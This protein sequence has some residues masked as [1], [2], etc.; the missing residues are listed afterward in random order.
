MWS[1]AR[2]SVRPENRATA[3]TPRRTRT[4]APVRGSVPGDPADFRVAGAAAWVP[5]DL[6]GA[7]L[8]GFGAV[9]VDVERTGGGEA[10]TLG[11]FSHG[12]HG[13]R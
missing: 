4:P 5:D 13:A 3:A 8:A 6:W 9:V 1:E 10:L 2:R 7:G 12:G 11:A